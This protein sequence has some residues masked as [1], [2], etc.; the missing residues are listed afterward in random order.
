[1][2]FFASMRCLIVSL[3]RLPSWSIAGLPLQ[4]TVQAGHPLYAMRMETKTSRAAAT[5]RSGEN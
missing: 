3:M 5:V 4:L 2:I 1:M